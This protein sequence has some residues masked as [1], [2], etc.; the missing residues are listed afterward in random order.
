MK[1]KRSYLI[2]KRVQVYICLFIICMCKGYFF[3]WDSKRFCT[4]KL[5]VCFTMYQERKFKGP[6]LHHQR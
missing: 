3:V 5:A 2:E 1:K 6:S 4:I